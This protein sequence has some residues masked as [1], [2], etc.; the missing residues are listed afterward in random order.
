MKV[1]REQAT[2]NRARILEAAGRLFRERGFEGVSV[3]EV[4]QAA[5]L[6][7]GGFYGH[8]KSKDDLIAQTLAALTNV[9]TGDRDLAAFAAAYL[10]PEHWRDVAGGCPVAALGV[11]AGRATP[12][13]K[14]AMTA[15]LRAQV[16]TLARTASGETPA[17]RRERALASWAAMVGAVVLARM[18][19]DPALAEEVV[20]AARA[21]IAD[22]AAG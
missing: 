7:H 21:F 10:A 19:D 16:E 3:A 14:A 5:G 18:S 15:G 11:E 1:T 2:A 13:A 22:D 20:S 4:M 9:R 8:F 6:T 17:A 12:E